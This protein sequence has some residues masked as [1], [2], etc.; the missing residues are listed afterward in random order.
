MTERQRA[1]VAWND[2]L[3]HFFDSG[4]LYQHD[5]DLLDRKKADAIDAAV[6]EA[7]K[8]RDATVKS[9]HKAWE[10]KERLIAEARRAEREKDGP[11]FTCPWCAVSLV[12]KIAHAQISHLI[13]CGDRRNAGPP[14]SAPEGLWYC[15]GCGYMSTG[16]ICTK[17][18]RVPSAPE[19]TK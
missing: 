5:V 17:C 1:E 7:V 2:L 15:K 13:E 8:E 19:G 14:A 12:D 6:A 3:R 16:P 18:G 9:L 11:L 10:E 4:R